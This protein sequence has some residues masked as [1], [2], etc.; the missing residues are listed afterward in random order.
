MGGDWLD[1]LIADRV[2]VPD[3]QRR[4]YAEELVYLPDAFLPRDTAAKPSS[5]PVSRSDE[6]LP[7]QAFVF[8][9]FNNTYKLNPVMFD[10]WM[11]LLREVEGSVL[12]LSEAIARRSRTLLR[13]ADARGVGHG[14]ARVRAVQAVARSSTSRVFSSPIYSWTRCPTTRI[15]PQAMRCGRGFRC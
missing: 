11:R 5:S 15:R 3:E 12:W 10:I 14:T 7:A 13:E 6:G 4:F 8:A 1:Y 2:V 9:C